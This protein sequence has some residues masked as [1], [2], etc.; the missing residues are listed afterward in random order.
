MDELPST[1]TLLDRIQRGDRGAINDLLGRYQERIHAMAR[2]RLGQRLRRKMD[3]LDI[4]QEAM[5]R[6]FKELW[7]KE[8]FDFS[9][10]GTFGRYVAQLVPPGYT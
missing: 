3:S 7:K 6:A 4:V 2:S 1:L 9:K 8:P 5:T 10:E